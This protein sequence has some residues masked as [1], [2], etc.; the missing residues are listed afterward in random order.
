MRGALQPPPHDQVG[1]LDAGPEPLVEKTVLQT[2]ITAT[3][4][5]IDRLVYESHGPMEEESR[6]V[7]EGT[8]IDATA[9]AEV[10]T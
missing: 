4:R 5:E 9:K 7:E 2:Q 8:D 3:D 10:F 1:R 6:I